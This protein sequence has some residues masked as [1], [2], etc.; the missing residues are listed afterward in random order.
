MDILNKKTE[1][2]KIGLCLSGGGALG[3]AHIGVL[4]A[5]LENGIIPDYI[6]GSSMGAIVGTLY[7]AG[8]SPDDMMQM[9]RE[10]R[11]YR[12]S[13]LMTFKPKFWKS[14]FSDH[15]TVRKLILE[16]IPHNS[17][18]KLA[19]KMHVCVVNTNTMEWEIKSSGGD[20]DAWVSASASIPGVFEAYEKDGIFYIDGGLLNN[21][22]AQPLKPLCDKIIGVDVL[23]YYPPQKMKKP[24]D[25]ITTSIRGV[26]HVN[27]LEGRSICDFIIEPTVVRRLNEFRF[28]AYQRI[29]K[30]GYR[31]A[32]VYIRTHPEIL[33]LKA[34]K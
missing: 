32:M 17:F 24:I 3:F 1:N 18:D 7:A 19:C 14:G 29:F 6:S 27:S 15:S 11:L 13:K 5:L 8:Y 20:L 30:Q 21:L 10:D 12:V 22:P 4:Q 31:D 9:I 2:T 16:T 33:K 25:A 28:D 23:P 34:I 26:Q